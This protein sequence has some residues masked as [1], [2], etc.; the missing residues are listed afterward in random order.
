MPKGL[1]CCPRCPVD[2]D[3]AGEILVLHKPRSVKNPLDEILSDKQQTADIFKAMVR[4]RNLPICV[5]SEYNRIVKYTQKYKIEALVKEGTSLDRVH[6]K[7]MDKDQ[8]EHHVECEHSCHL[9]GQS[10]NIQWHDCRQDS[11]VIGHNYTSRD[12]GWGYNG[13]WVSYWLS[14]LRILQQ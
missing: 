11:T 13:G 14:S 2:Y 7:D 6:I 8:L 10:T 5:M 9:S 4:S 1:N 3:Y 12:M